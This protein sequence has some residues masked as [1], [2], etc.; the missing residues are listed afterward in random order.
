MSLN[1]DYYHIGREIGID[2]GHRV[3]THGS[4]CGS[5]HGHRYKI[6]AECRSMLLG[7]GVESG[8][9]LDFGFLK[10]EMMD[11][12]DAPCDH[13]MILDINDPLCGMFLN[14]LTGESMDEIRSEVSA[15]GFKEYP[16]IRADSNSKG[17]FRNKLYFVNF[18]PTA[19]NLAKHWF[20]RLA[21]RVLK[22]T[23]NRAEL[24][25]VTVWET[26]NCHSYYDKAKN[27]N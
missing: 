15:H 24:T 12:I 2:A 9:V 14:E 3:W 22:R 7:S 6:I 27:F 26:P 8:M 20:D 16:M 1:R 18:V 17:L 23:K 21:P 13:G 5:F 11:T 10:E 4:K 25:R 19:E